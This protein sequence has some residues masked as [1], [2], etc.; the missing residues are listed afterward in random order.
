MATAA[1]L[2]RARMRTNTAKALAALV[3]LGGAGAACSGEDGEPE[4]RAAAREPAGLTVEATTE[5]AFATQ[6]T[7]VADGDIWLPNPDDGQVTRVDGA[8]GEIVTEIPVGDPDALGFNPDPQ[9]VTTDPAGQVWAGIFSTDS[10]DRID[11]ATNQVVESVP[12]GIDPYGIA[13]TDTD[14]WATDFEE[15]LVIRVDRA[16]GAEVARITDVVTSPTAVL[17]ALD[18]IWVA[19][20]RS[21]RVVRIDPGTNTVVGMAE[22][23]RT[24]EAMIEYDGAIWLASN[25]GHGLK[26]IDPVTFEVASIALGGNAY[27]VA[28]GPDG[29]WVTVGP[30]EGCDDRNSFVV[31]VDPERL[32]EVDRLPVECAFAVGALA[33]GRVLVGIDAPPA[34]LAVVRSGS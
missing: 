24:V 1:P 7:T 11:P 31:L 21:G 16:T 26:R 5:A 9:S 2:D 28:G 22:T 14:I 3:L 23:R 29:L 20:H 17:H 34:R 32:A 25:S 6:F 33:G 18:A 27:G 15:G 10:A 13:V 4:P 30:H 8:T 19:H 12:L